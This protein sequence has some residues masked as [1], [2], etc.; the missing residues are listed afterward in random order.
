MA[1]TA[2]PDPGFHPGFPVFDPIWCPAC[3]MWVNGPTQWEDHKIGKKHNKNLKKKP[4]LEASK[5]GGTKPPEDAEGVKI[6]TPEEHGDPQGM[7]I[8]EASTTGGNNP[9]EED[10]ADWVK[11]TPDESMGI[12]KASTCLLTPDESMGIRKARTWLLS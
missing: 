3:D 12:C 8:L 11:I 10:D 7:R 2:E 6:T 1:H 5:K 9:P 4:I